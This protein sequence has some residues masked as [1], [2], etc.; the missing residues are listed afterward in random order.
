M[1]LLLTLLLTLSDTFPILGHV[2]ATSSVSLRDATSITSTTQFT[3]N[4][5]FSSA[6]RRIKVSTLPPLAS[7]RTEGDAER[8]ATRERVE[9]DRRFEVEAAIIRVM[10]ARKRLEHNLLVAEVTRMLQR[11]FAADP[12][13]IKKRIEDLIERE[14][15]ER[16]GMYERKEKGKKKGSIL[17]TWSVGYEGCGHVVSCCCS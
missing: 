6:L 11:R 9:S 2:R 16:D 1:T 7:G 14:F 8:R 5:D 10:K 13:M 3:F 15:L 12:V 4:Y 17:A